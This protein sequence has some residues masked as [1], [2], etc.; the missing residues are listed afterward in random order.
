MISP[1]TIVVAAHR[2]D[3]AAATLV[4][5]LRR[6]GRCPAILVDDAALTRAVVEHRPSSGAVAP[7]VR[8]APDALPGDAL[9]LDSGETVDAASS[10]VVWRLPS[11]PAPTGPAAH[12]DYAEAE[13]FA[14]GLSWLAGLGGSVLNRPDPQSL[15]GVLPH[16]FRLQAAA[17][18]AGL[19]LPAFRLSSD[20]TSASSTAGMSASFWPVAQVPAR[21]RGE[22]EPAGGPP[23]PAPR[24]LLEDVEDPTSVLVLIDG[25]DGI[26][27]GPHPQLHRPLTTLV[28]ALGLSCAEVEVARA[29]GRAVVTGVSPTPG[30]AGAGHATALAAYVEHRALAHPAL[31]KE[32]AA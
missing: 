8:P 30:L 15:P 28:G 19:D 22:R 27:V 5:L 23:I 4:A 11:F 1:R 13:A 29:S 16:L 25:D 21:A 17:R 6:R 7:G 2:G 32:A 10:L 9:R 31:V 12:R 24:L 14:L 18:A 20:A 3:V 26:V